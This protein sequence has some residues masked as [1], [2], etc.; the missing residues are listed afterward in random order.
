MVTAG[1]H[2]EE[3]WHRSSVSGVALYYSVVADEAA[4]AA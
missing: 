1:R 4:A 3:K 2:G